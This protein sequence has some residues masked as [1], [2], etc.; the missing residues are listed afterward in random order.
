[1]TNIN[2][3]LH[4]LYDIND[5]LKLSGLKLDPDATYHWNIPKEV[6]DSVQIRENGILQESIFL[7]LETGSERAKVMKSVKGSEQYRYTFSFK[8]HFDHKAIA[9]T[10]QH[11][12]KPDQNVNFLTKTQ[13]PVTKQGNTP[14]VV[15]LKP[16][17]HPGHYRFTDVFEVRDQD[18]VA[19]IQLS[20]VVWGDDGMISKKERAKIYFDGQEI[21]GDAIYKTHQWSKIKLHF[22][23]INEGCAIKAAAQD[24]LFAKTQDKVYKIFQTTNIAY[25]K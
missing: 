8:K 7:D 3:T 25:K 5:F 12:T 17:Q 9:L 15:K 23:S 2:L 1:M 20:P 6:L 22:P 14:P 4:Q 18:G 24:V 21:R 10:I 11:P 19:C 13:D 16:I